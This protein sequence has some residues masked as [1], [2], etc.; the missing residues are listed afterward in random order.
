MKNDDYLD[1]TC[2]FTGHRPDKCKGTEEEIRARLADEIQKAIGEGYDT[3]ISGMA[4]GVDTWAAEEVLKIKSE[5]DEIKLIAAIPF[6]GV[7]KNRTAELQD[8]FEAIVEKADDVQFICQKYQR[9]AFRARDAW[10]VDHASR[11]IAVFNGSQG[12]TEWT[13]HYAKKKNRTIALI[14]DAECMEREC[15]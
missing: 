12:G 6:P 3:F 14:N 15:D 7:E 4:S 10:M 8:R 9:L 1:R 11:V 2:C 5:N 13:I